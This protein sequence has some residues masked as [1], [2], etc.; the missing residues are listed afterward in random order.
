MP[1]ELLGVQPTPKPRKRS[2]WGDK[3][4]P[5]G[6]AVVESLRRRTISGYVEYADKEYKVVDDIPETRRGI[7]REL[8]RPQL[9][10]TI[11]QA[12]QGRIRK[13][14][15]EDGQQGI[16]RVYESFVG[17]YRPR[18]GVKWKDIR[19][20]DDLRWHNEGVTIAAKEIR[21]VRAELAT[22]AERAV[23]VPQEQFFPRAF[24][25]AGVS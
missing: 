25:F 9:Y 1:G 10:M 7:L 19:S 5:E 24:V 22:I 17:A 13:I 20:E 4:S 18:R 12:A 14:E 11:R 2:Y 15:E 16:T 21:N 23:K 6:R 8:T 3:L